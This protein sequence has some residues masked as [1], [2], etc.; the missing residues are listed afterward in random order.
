[1]RKLDLYILDFLFLF[2]DIFFQNNSF[3][4]FYLKHNI[5][6]EILYQMKSYIVKR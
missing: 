3:K 2:F 4:I 5:D 6:F 1:M